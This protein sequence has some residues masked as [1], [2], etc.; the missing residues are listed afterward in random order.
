MTVTVNVHQAKTHLSK[1]LERVRAGEDVVVAK[2]GKPVARLVPIEPAR[3]PRK[4]GS[5]KGLFRMSDDFD[6]P[7]PDDVLDSF[8]R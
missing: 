6:D 5:A 3:A 2:S 8:E 4:P 7:L 1:L